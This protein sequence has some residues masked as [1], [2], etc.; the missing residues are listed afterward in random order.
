[1]ELKTIWERY[2]ETSSRCSKIEGQRQ[3]KNNSRVLSCDQYL[4][5][6]ILLL[7]SS[8]AVSPDVN[9]WDVISHQEGISKRKRE[10]ENERDLAEQE[11][12]KLNLSHVDEREK[13]LVYLIFCFAVT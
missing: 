13:H 9:E 5:S 7:S 3:A 10:K 11:L 1:M 12:S 6:T 4:Y 8:K 2:V